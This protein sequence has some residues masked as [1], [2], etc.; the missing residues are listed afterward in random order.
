MNKRPLSPADENGPI[1]WSVLEEFSALQK[2]G[3]P[4]VRVRLITAYLT[5]ASSLMEDVR[6]AIRDADTQTLARAAHNMKPGSMNVG[7]ITLG[8]LFAELEQIS[9]TGNLTD[10]P[11]LYE[12]I[13]ASYLSCISALSHFLENVS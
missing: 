10:A 6:Q 1:D 3:M 12:R 9:K 2:P 11:A 13:E 4:D 7:A 5:S 8:N